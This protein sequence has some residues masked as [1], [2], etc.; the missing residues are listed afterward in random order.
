MQLFDSLTN[1]KR[2]FIPLEPGKVKMYS[3]GP[4]VYNYFHLGNARPFVVFDLLRRYLEYRGYKVTFVQNFTD[5][6][7][8]MIRRANEEGVT[9]RELADKYI[10]EYFKDADGLGI[11]R[12][13]IQPRATES[14][15][16][17]IEQVGKLVAGGHA[18]VSSDGVYFSTR[19]FPD[20]GKLSHFHLDELEAGASERVNTGENKHDPADF[21]VWKFKKPG[22]PAW[23]SPWGEGRPGWHI[24]CSSMINRYL[25]STIDIHSGGKDLIFPHHE[26]EI[27]QSECATGKQLA[28]YWLHN[29]F[30]NVNNEKMSKSL[31]NFFTVRDVVKHFPYD[32]IRF[33]LLTG[34]YRSPIN[35]SDELLQAAQTGLTRLRNCYSAVQF[36]LKSKVESAE[37]ADKAAAAVAES[38]RKSIDTARTAFIAAMDDD[39]N[40][41]DALAAIFSWVREVNTLITSSPSAADC[42]AV[43]DFFDELGDVLGLRWQCEEAIP[44]EILALV[45]ARTQA[46][47]AKNFTL[48]DELRKQITEAG[49]TLMDTPQGPRIEKQHA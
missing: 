2:E 38:V 31:G 12:A 25:G 7:D 46:K 23:P 24:E 29:G 28:H 10:A 49:Y 4:T 8:K 9:L 14:I 48:A 41:P 47:K 26:N 18:Y 42:Q 30:I 3:C 6:D 16:A 36:K 15:D 37:S 44:T 11:K 40:T 27:A 5:I 32:V 21:A 20:Y 33:F 1:Q 35:F 39:L 17:I 34:H 45:E 43:L 19:S 22:E 13:T